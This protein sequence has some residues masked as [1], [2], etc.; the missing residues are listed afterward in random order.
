MSKEPPE[1]RDTHMY[2]KIQGCELTEDPEVMGEG[3]PVCDNTVMVVNWA[4]NMTVSVWS[5]A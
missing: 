2:T 4:W 1:Q 5:G 3:Y